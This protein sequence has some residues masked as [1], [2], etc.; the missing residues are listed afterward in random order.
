MIKAERRW[1]LANPSLLLRSHYDYKER[2]KSALWVSAAIWCI[3]LAAHPTWELSLNGWIYLSH[4]LGLRWINCLHGGTEMET[5]WQD[6][7][8]HLGFKARTWSKAHQIKPGGKAWGFCRALA[9]RCQKW[10]GHRNGAALLWPGKMAKGP[11][12][13][14]NVIQ[15]LNEAALPLT[16]RVTHFSYTPR[17]ITAVG[18]QV[19]KQQVNLPTNKSWIKFLMLKAL[20]QFGVWMF[21]QRN[22]QNTAEQKKISLLSMIWKL[23]SCRYF[24]VYTNVILVLFPKVVVTR[25][26]LFEIALKISWFFS[27][28]F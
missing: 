28:V 21:H 11:S 10:H 22:L 17:W 19:G 18:M 16:G 8:S 27:V 20:T 13:Y 2:G 14:W 4:W 7:N 25:T 12:G 26:I 24:S 3:H 23:S 5:T 9:Q 6:N 1:K 15:T